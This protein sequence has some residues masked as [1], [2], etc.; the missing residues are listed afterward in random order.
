MTAAEPPEALLTDFGIGAPRARACE[1]GAAVEDAS[2]RSPEEIRGEHPDARSNVYSLACI[3]VECLTGEPLYA[4][5]RPLLTLQGHLTEP[6]PKLSERE[7]GLP[8]A[9]DAVVAAALAK[10]PRERQA[11]PGALMRAA[12][13]AL[14]V[15]V[16]IPIVRERKEPKGAA[17]AAPPVKPVP[18]AK[19]PAL[20]PRTRKASPRRPARALGR[21]LRAGGRRVAAG[22]RRAAV[23][24][25]QGAAALVALVLMASAAAGFATGTSGDTGQSATSAPVAAPAAAAE[26]VSYPRVDGVVERLN[27]RRA[28]ARQRL[29]AADTDSEQAAAAE[30][31]ESAY[32]D[33]YQGLEAR[34]G[35]RAELAER[36]RAVAQAYGLLVAAARSADADTWRAARERTL[37]RERDLELMLRNRPWT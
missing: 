32:R 14:D 34:S 25:P 8:E 7:A 37:D 31:A 27:A 10:D 28:T 19:L 18:E 6:P 20:P 5:D 26:T 1:L 21:G 30:A 33:A 16:P 12:E 35:A 11:S 36:L 23:L 24:V 2:Y 3:L 4:Y 29:R 9:L 22:G 17:S 15:R 13:E